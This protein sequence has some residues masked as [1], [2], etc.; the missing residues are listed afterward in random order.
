MRYLFL[1]LATFTLTSCDKGADDARAAADSKLLGERLIAEH[2]EG[3]LAEP[4]LVVYDSGFIVG[5]GTTDPEFGA[6]ANALKVAPG[7]S[8]SAGPSPVSVNEYYSQEGVEFGLSVAQ[9]TV[10]VDSTSSLTIRLLFGQEGIQA[11]R[12]CEAV[13]L[14]RVCKV[15]DELRAYV[16]DLAPLGAD[17][18]DHG[19]E[20]AKAEL[21]KGWVVFP[22]APETSDKAQL[23]LVL[24]GGVHCNLSKWLVD[25][26]DSCTM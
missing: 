3:V 2:G 7:S 8:L 4:V 17:L 19:S 11:L 14:D 18:L 21:R 6:K 24:S 1:V 25:P 20:I 9:K 16:D 12:R 5:S 15:G 23:E 10:V 26:R 13:K 22:N